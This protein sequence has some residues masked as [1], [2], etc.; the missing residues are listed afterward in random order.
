MLRV[1]NTLSGVKED[2]EPRDPSQ[3]RVYVCGI[4]PYD[5]S[6][7]GHGMS[8]VVFDV[9]RRYLEYRGY[10]VRLVQNFTDVDDKIIERAQTLG[11]SVDELAGR[12][13]DRYFEDMELLH[14]RRADE[15]PRA[16]QEV[17]AI[18]TMIERL[19]GTGHAYPSNGDVY[20]R[21]RSLDDYGKL[22]HRSLDGMV[23]GA[24]VAV[25]EAKEHPLDFTLWKGAKPG[26]P[27]WDSPWGPGRP[28]WHIECSAM[29]LNYLGEALDI[30]GGGQDLI[31]PHHENEIAQ[32]EAFTGVTP[33]A[34]YWLHNGLLR[35]GDEKM[36][37]SKGN[38]I[39][40]RDAVS[41][42]GAD[43]FRVFILMSHYRSPLTWSEEGLASA[44]RAAQRLA[45]AAGPESADPSGPDGSLDPEPFRARFESALDDD[46]NTPQA[47]AV[48][49]DLAHGINRATGA[50]DHARTVLRELGEVL[51]LTLSADGA[52]LQEAGPFI[53]LLIATRSALRTE[54]QYGLA[55]QIRN[56]LAEL[57]VALEDT[58]AGTEWEY[59]RS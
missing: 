20:Y 53:E 30:H 19:V 28:G 41:R 1:S 49:F 56:Q 2:F 4:T 18:V 16:T 37:K 25:V 39:T 26:E 15:Y 51:G 50:T 13:I 57:G 21:V 55:D 3:V 10:G 54:R 29:S 22:S 17:P 31:F 33:F 24:R 44:A 32:S 47:L 8:Y 58:A 52:A 59:R 9:I 27:S 5:E 34:K 45:R 12:F 38:L 46:F 42:Y 36:S 23:A 14:V 43:A 35:M 48:L 6:H 40:I 7:V 11:V